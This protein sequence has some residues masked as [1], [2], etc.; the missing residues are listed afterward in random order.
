MNL[1][2]ELFCYGIGKYL[3]MKN[4][5]N[6]SA[7]SKQVKSKTDLVKD[8]R[9]KNKDLFCKYLLSMFE[10]VDD[11]E[12]GLFRI[13]YT[14]EIKSIISYNRFHNVFRIEYE[15]FHF[16]RDGKELINEEAIREFA[17][18]FFSK[19]EN[20]GKRYERTKIIVKN[21]KLHEYVLVNEL[22]CLF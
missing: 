16:R 13:E 14:G 4:V 6:L 19:T 17:N 1:P 3:T 11:A 18:L 5:A 20:Y 9:E 10:E 22:E 2:D 7:T 8:E 15:D 21:G 12:E